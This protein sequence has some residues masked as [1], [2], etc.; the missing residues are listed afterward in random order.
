MFKRTDF[1]LI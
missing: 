1:S